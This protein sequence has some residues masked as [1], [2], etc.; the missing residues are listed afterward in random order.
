MAVGAVCDRLGAEYEV[1][2]SLTPDVI[3]FLEEL[4]D[5]GLLDVPSES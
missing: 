2:E 1:D 5:A 4:R 3:G